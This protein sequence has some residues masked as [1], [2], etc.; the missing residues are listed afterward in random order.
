M[1]PRHAH[2]KPAYNRKG[3]MHSVP[4]FLQCMP[5]LAQHNVVQ[6]GSTLLVLSTVHSYPD[7]PDKALS[8]WIS[9]ATT[10]QL[11]HA[12]LTSFHAAWLPPRTD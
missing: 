1:K 5:P 11:L 9:F 2:P 10:F 3:F 4:V 8:R 6:T 7:K 12:N